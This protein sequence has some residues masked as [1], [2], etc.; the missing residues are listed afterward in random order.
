MIYYIIS[1]LLFV[2]IIAYLFFLY[3][4][5]IKIEK[6]E[7]KIIYKF[8]EKNNQIPSIYVVTQ[9]YLNKHDDIFKEILKLKKKDFSDN[10]SYTSFIEKLHNY[11]LINN[12]LKFIFKVC[13]KHPKLHKNSKFL[14]IKDIIIEKSCEIDKDIKQYKTILKQY[15]KM[16]HIKNFTII[17]LLISTSKKNKV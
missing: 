3:L 15:N 9:N 10:T 13:D 14:F 4:L 8:K 6:N 11:K 12:E 5:H 7:Q 1:L 16:V 17:W 2:V